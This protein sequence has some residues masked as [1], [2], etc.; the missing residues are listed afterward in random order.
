MRK[1]KARRGKIRVIG[2]ADGPTAIFTASR[3]RR[4][5]RPGFGS[6]FAA[7]AAFLLV[8]ALYRK[9]KTF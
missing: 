6:L 5:A 9:Y 7:L 1:N 4:G 3:A 8:A 2:G